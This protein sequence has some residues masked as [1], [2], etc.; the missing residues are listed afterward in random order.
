[1][2]IGYLRVSSSYERQVV[3]LQLD[4]LLAAGVDEH[5]VRIL[6]DLKGRGWPSAPLRRASTPRPPHGEFLY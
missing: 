6:N 2:L 3:D 5:L 4:A 1:M